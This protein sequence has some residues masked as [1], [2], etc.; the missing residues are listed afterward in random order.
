MTHDRPADPLLTLLLDGREAAHRAEAAGRAERVRIA[1][2]AANTAGND[3]ERQARAAVLM[4]EATGEP[5]RYVE[6]PLRPYHSKCIGDFG[7]PG[8]I[9]DS[10]GNSRA[11]D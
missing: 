4:D 7:Q 11:D 1:Q 3:L 10:N 8:H 6:R 2:Y 5:H 9:G